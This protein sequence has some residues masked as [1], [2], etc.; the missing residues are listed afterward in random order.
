MRAGDTEVEAVDVDPVQPLRQLA[1]RV[2]QPLR[3]RQERG[4]RGREDQGIVTDGFAGGGPHGAP[5][6][7]HAGDIASV[8]DIGHALGKCGGQDADA[9]VLW[10]AE[11]RV[12][13]QAGV[14]LPQGPSEHLLEGRLR[15]G[16][17]DP[18]GGDVPEV[19]QPHLPVVGEHEML[20]DPIAEGLQGPVVE[21]LAAIPGLLGRAAGAGPSI[22]KALP[23]AVHALEDHRGRQSVGVGLEG[24]REQLAV[25]PDGRAP[26]DLLERPW[27]QAVDESH[28]LRIAQ[29]QQVPRV[30]EDELANAARAAQP[31]RFRLALQDDVLAVRQV[32]RRREAG[33]PRANDDDHR[34]WSLVGQVPVPPALI[35]PARAPP[36]MSLRPCPVRPA[37][38]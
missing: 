30:V 34:G 4:E 18:V 21:G 5:G 1:Q 17:G 6:H 38:G 29:V 37:S 2:G 8:A 16:P 3:P 7:I 33:Q 9:S 10:I 28:D 14:R 35:Q 27:Q 31:A 26:L 13:P 25:R 24:V 15:D 20:R 12:V 22:P 36:D 23:E 19:P 11:A 32:Q